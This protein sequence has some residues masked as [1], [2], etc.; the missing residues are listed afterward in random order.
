MVTYFICLKSDTYLGMGT[1]WV[2]SGIGVN[3][4][5]LKGYPYL[6]CV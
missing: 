3:L 2:L 6:N 5:L 4:L 1:V